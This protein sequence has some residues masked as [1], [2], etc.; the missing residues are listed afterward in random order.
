MKRSRSWYKLNLARRDRMCR[1]IPPGKPALMVSMVRK[2]PR[3]P[4]AD[5]P[6]HAV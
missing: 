6:F 3:H 2:R 1:A 4:F 5:G